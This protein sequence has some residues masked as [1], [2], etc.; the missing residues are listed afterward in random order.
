MNPTTLFTL[1]LDPSRI[2]LALG[3]TPDPWQRDL[4]LSTHRE[5]LLNCSRQSGKSTTVAALAVHTAVFQPRSLILILSP[6]LRQST[7]FYRK[8]KDAYNAIKRPLGAVVENQITLELANGSRI[9]SLPGTEATIRSYSNVRLV[10]IDEASRVADELYKSVRPM[11]AVSNGR[12]I[13]LS[14][15]FGQRGFF[16]RE[17]HG[18]NSFHKVEIPWRMCPRITEEFIARERASLGDDW[19]AQEYNCSFVSVVGL[20]YP[21]FERAIIEICPPALTN[22]LVRVGGI[23]FGWRNPF[24]AVW[25]VLHRPDDTLYLTGERY[26]R[27]TPLHEHAT[28]LRSLKGVTWYADPSGATEMAELRR[29]GVVVRR[30]DNE[31][32]PGIAAVTAR[33]RTGRLK[34]VRGSCPNLI[35]ESRQYRYPTQDERAVLGENP[36]D[37]DNHA[38]AALRYLVSRL[39]ARIM[40]RLKRRADDGVP[41]RDTGPEGDET[42]PA[43]DELTHRQPWLRIDNE[44]LWETF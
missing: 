21:D 12:L 3:I 32:R 24:A 43:K 1:G 6:G 35:T 30:G 23:D 28:F 34:V 2:L 44:A 7:E 17:W 11:L 15:P 27:E 36:I 22:T 18:Q 38:L 42:Q 40:A 31:I 10:I 8:A 33:I 9:I 26:L 19:V 25:G 29:A 5:I 20:V 4:L 39:D 41:E 37:A 13:V 16:W 14:T